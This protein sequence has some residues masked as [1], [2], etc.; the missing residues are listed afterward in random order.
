MIIVVNLINEKF[1]ESFRWLL[2]IWRY[3][4]KTTFFVVLITFPHKCI[5]NVPTWKWLEAAR[6]TEQN[7]SGFEEEVKSAA[8]VDKT[9][10]GVVNVQVCQFFIISSR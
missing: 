6:H 7:R 5:V 4:F 3:S 10:R 8:E 2:I 1:Y 9:K